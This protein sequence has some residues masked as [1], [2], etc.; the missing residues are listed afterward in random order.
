MSN[1]LALSIPFFALIFL[2][3]FAR[4]IGFIR[5]DGALNL[6]KFA[7]FVAL[8]PMMFMNVAAGTPE[9]ILGS[10]IWN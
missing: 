1:V 9:D 10:H 4:A 7:F 5:E 6:S 3:M 2:G 8:P